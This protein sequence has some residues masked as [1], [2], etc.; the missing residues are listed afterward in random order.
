MRA[1]LPD[2]SGYL[3]RGGVKLYWELF[4][5]GDQTVFFLPTWS[6]IHSRHW[7]AQ[8]PYFGC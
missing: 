1:R 4:G 2:Q 5:S 6:I 8:I 7:K 3:D